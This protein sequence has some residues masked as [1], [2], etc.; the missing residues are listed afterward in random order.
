M[1]ALA[2]DVERARAA[3]SCRLLKQ[4]VEF[5]EPAYVTAGGMW[6]ACVKV[7]GSEATSPASSSSDEPQYVGPLPPPGLEALPRVRGHSWDLPPAF[8]WGGSAL[9]ALCTQPLES[10][11]LE[12]DDP[13]I[14]VA[15]NMMRPGRRTTRRRHCRVLM[16]ERLNEL[17]KENAACVIYV[18]YINRLGF[19]SAELLREHYE[20]YGPVV[21]VLLSNA[22][23]RST[24]GPF[25]QRVRPSRIGF[26]LM[27][28]PEDAA[29]AIAAGETQI[30]SGV[31]V[32]IRNFEPRA[33]RLEEAGEV[34]EGPAGAEE[35]GE[36]ADC[37]GCHESESG[38]RSRC[39]SA[40]TATPP[41]SL[42]DEADGYV[43]AA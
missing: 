19:S 23:E 22:H 20:Q 41:E 13:S 9:P 30:V 4:R 7:P 1:A 8:G 39:T 5:G 36:G 15:T 40:S 34:G 17:Q 18:G 2:W 29:R 26:I 28:K 25:P 37:S 10:A 11:F 42:V 35:E 31:S 21:K 38:M 32:L 27:E 6:P 14:A 3:L 43:S 12:D 24:D 33:C 16:A